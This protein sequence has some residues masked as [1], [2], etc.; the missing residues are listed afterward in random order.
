[1]KIAKAK[2]NWTL[3]FGANLCGRDVFFRVWAP[4]A[5]K[6]EILFPLQGRREE[7]HKTDEGY[8]SI[9]ARGLKAGDLYQYLLD[10]KGPF[11]DPCSRY[12]PEGPGGPSM[13]IDPN[14]FRWTD[15]RWRG[16][17]LA[18][19]IIYELHVGTFTREGTFDALRRQLRRIRDS[20]MTVIEIMPVA[21][22]PGQWNWGYDGVDFYAP[23][24]N[25]GTPDDFRSLVDEAHRLG[26]GIIL[27]V[28][29][30]HFGPDMNFLGEFSRDYYSPRYQ[31]EWGQSPNFDGAHCRPV[32]TFF[33]ENACYWISEFHL[34]GLRF[35]A[36]QAIYDRSPVHFLAEAARCARESA[37]GREILLIAESERQNIRIVR[38][39][40]R[41]GYGFDGI[42]SDDFHHTV[43]VALTGKKEAY[44]S[45]FKGAAQELLSCVKRGFLFQG[46]FSQWQKKKRGTATQDTP[47]ETFVFFLQNHDQVANDCL[48]WRLNAL[49]S[50]ARYRAM[51]ALF[52]LS[53]MTPLFFMGQEYGTQ[54][55]FV[56]F[57]DHRPDLSKLVSSGRKKFLEQFSS[58]KIGWVRDR[59]PDPAAVSAF[60]RCRLDDAERRKNKRW[61][62]F[63]R[64]LIRLRQQDPLLRRQSREKL[65]GAVL[66]NRCIALRYFS[67]GRD[68]RE[69]LLIVNWGEAFD[70]IPVSEP[71]LA[72]TAGRP[73][74]LIWASDHIRYGGK[75]RRK[76]FSFW[77]IPA[78]AA[79]FFSS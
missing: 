73:W 18:G 63:H 62:R 61:T 22:F 75:R 52:L 16:L 47:A 8:F 77:K 17:R 29:Y 20:G 13:I 42:W 19:Q 12:Q 53:P 72:E 74:K 45:D 64:D 31:S 58:C 33:V 70:C 66:N 54:K 3:P 34:D 43:R 6:V 27:D 1:M 5:K 56:Y 51:T 41:G 55:P 78:E 14:Q 36:T 46:Q 11:P 35:D 50:E 48:G 59:I 44:F 4:R 71:L 38:P 68:P 21:D 49:T 24:R 32:R 10:G 65:D 30:N 25:Y 40:E 2:K 79:L 9:R 57:T 28:V 15:R 23:S 60:R 69:R 39:P 7:L 76:T 67:E 26:L 37:A